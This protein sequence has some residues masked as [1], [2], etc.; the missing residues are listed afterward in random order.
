MPSATLPFSDNTT[1]LGQRTLAI[2]K[3]CLEGNNDINSTDRK[4]V[5]EYQA[6][7]LY[8]IQSARLSK[9]TYEVLQLLVGCYAKYGKGTV[10]EETLTLM[11]SNLPFLFV[12]DCFSENTIESLLFLLSS[13]GGMELI[14]DTVVD[15]IAGHNDD[16]AVEFMG[17]ISLVPRLIASVFNDN[18]EL[19]TISVVGRFVQKV[20]KLH[21][22]EA[23]MAEWPEY[24]KKDVDVLG[25]PRLLLFLCVLLEAIAQAGLPPPS[26]W[27]MFLVDWS[28]LNAYE[29][30]E[31]QNVIVLVN[32]LCCK[33]IHLVD[34]V[35]LEQLVNVL[36]ALYKKQIDTEQ[37]DLISQMCME[38]LISASSN[39][40]EKALALSQE[41][42]Q[43]H[44]TVISNSLFINSSADL[45]LDKKSLF[46]AKYANWCFC[47][48]DNMQFNCLLHLIDDQV[49][50]ELV[51]QE[52]LTTETIQKLPQDRLF[53]VI[54]Q[55]SLYDYST[56]Y[57]LKEMSSIL[58]NYLSP[59]DHTMTNTEI[60]KLK[61][62][63][64]DNIVTKRLV[65][66]G[67]WEN[68]LKNC[69]SEMVNGR[70]IRDILAV[71]VA[72]TTT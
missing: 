60:W 28:K 54:R 6:Q 50:F 40:P 56:E 32:D 12:L 19:D 71:E 25:Q 2:V 58:S 62:E 59:I 29:G 64:L 10:F 1:D 22:G 72:R 42:I 69:L 15:R 27:N 38:D 51:T 53:R 65:Q 37:M 33:I 39:G 16:E 8:L 3:E 11:L 44:P 48:A 43:Q 49:F 17:R 24:Q 61:K 52:L 35:Y 47:G 20:C 45:F 66:L 46:D 67:G 57:L 18:P 23:K 26:A 30:F 34:F 63:L 14:L 9:E 36:L 13:T 31:L 68:S 7:F 5:I 55:L 70:K 21:P 41:F 4:V